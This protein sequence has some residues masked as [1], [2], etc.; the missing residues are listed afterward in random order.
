MVS[1]I[2]VDG[3][4]N[5]DILY[6]QFPL[7]VK[8]EIQSV[9]LNPNVS[10]VHI[11]DPSAF[12]SYSTK[13]A[14]AWLTRLD[15]LFSLNLT[16]DNSDSWSWIWKLRVPENLK[17][18]AWLIMHNCLPT[19]CFIFHRHITQDASCHLCCVTKEIILHVLCDFLRLTVHG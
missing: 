3:C 18:F 6:T 15:D 8:L 11:W 16:N 12:G 17:H 10:N 2:Y 19:N 7:D 9:F 4:W 13:C 1:D 5:F 14:Y